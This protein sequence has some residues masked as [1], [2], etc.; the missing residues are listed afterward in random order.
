MPAALVVGGGLAGCAAAVRLAARGWR[1]TLLERHPRL[2][3]KVSSFPWPAG[4][5]AWADNGQHAAT[6]AC[7][8]LRAF[9]D[10]IGAAGKIR[11]QERLRVP[12]AAPGGRVSVLARW[13]LPPPLHLIPGLMVFDLL[14]L[15]DRMAAKRVLDACREPG[16]EGLTFQ[17]WLERLGQGPAAV[18][19]FWD[20]MVYAVCNAPSSEISAAAGAWVVREGLLTRADALDLG[21]ATAP[22]AGLVE[23]GVR[24]FLSA[25]GGEVRPGG[26][27]EAL[28][29]EGARCVGVRLKGGEG[30][31]ADA[32]VLAVP[33]EEAARLLERPS[34]RLAPGAILSV[35]LRLDR[36]VLPEEAREGFAAL[37]EGP[38]QWVFSKTRLWGLDPAEGELLSLVLC[39][40]GGLAD[41]PGDALVRRALEALSACLPRMREASVKAAVVMKERRATFLPA[42]GAEAERPGTAVPG[43]PGLALA[44]AWTATGWPATMEGAVRS[45]IAAADHLAPA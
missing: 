17:A 27:V 30:L 20:P 40:T 19:G 18:R 25:R 8:A 31:S 44:G 21:F 28:R 13:D 41:L 32:V 15:A 16:P 45:G 9:L 42:P 38:V 5:V 14:P 37:V 11:W 35:T 4:G 6:K 2:G 26:G 36:P 24:A 1:V 7:T 39:G 29:R 34:A 10:E 23:P 12:F 33:W 43:V 3:G 22:Q